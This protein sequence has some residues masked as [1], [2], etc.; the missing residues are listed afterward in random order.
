[1]LISSMIVKVVPEMAEEVVLKLNKIPNVTT[2]GVH[3]E[4]NI[5][6]VAEMETEEQLEDLSNH[7]TNEYDGVLNVY[8]TYVSSDLEER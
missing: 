2:Y 5:I 8:F 7:I 4:N 3:K 1:M 6:I